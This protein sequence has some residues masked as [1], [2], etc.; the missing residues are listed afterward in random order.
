MSNAEYFGRVKPKRLSS[1]DED[2]KADQTKIL[3]DQARFKKY[4][5]NKQSLADLIASGKVVQA[6][7]LSRIKEDEIAAQM[8]FNEAVKSEESHR[9]SKIKTDPDSAVA[10][11]TREPFSD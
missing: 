2:I 3:G 5:T 6:A 11:Y 8:A 10:H 9:R 1:L 4:G 7:E